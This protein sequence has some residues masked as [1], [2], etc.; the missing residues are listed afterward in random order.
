M[1]RHSESTDGCGLFHRQKGSA[2]LT[3]PCDQPTKQEHKLFKEQSD[4]ADRSQLLLLSKALASNPLGTTWS[5]PGSQEFQDHREK[6]H[7][8][9]T[10]Q[11]RE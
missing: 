7:L 9:T 11:V 3:R 6:F 4:Q 10:T 1:V 2:H 5:D 8:D